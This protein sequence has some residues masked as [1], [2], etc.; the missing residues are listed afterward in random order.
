MRFVETVGRSRAAGWGMLLG[1][2]AQ[3][4]PILSFS[5]WTEPLRVY[6]VGRYASLSIPIGW[7]LI[8]LA[9]VVFGIWTIRNA[10]HRPRITTT[11][12]QLRERIATKPVP[13]WVC[14]HCHS[15]M[16]VNLTGECLECHSRVDCLEVASEGD[17]RTALTALG[18]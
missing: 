7:L 1:G 18:R 5:D 10:P 11:P 15:F 8:A 9:M 4:V 6:R 3:L 13:F 12:E 17:R 14:L 16:D 2:L